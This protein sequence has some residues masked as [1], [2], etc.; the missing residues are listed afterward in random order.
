MPDLLAFL[1][2]KKQKRMIF[3]VESDRDKAA[4]NADTELIA[5]AIQYSSSG[6]I[7]E[8]LTLAGEN[9]FSLHMNKNA[10]PMQVDRAKKVALDDVNILA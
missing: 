10:G 7:I 1:T 4:L 2:K 3:F 6:D 5:H 9:I 8:G